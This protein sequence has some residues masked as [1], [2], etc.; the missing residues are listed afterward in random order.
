M[1]NTKHYIAKVH[2]KR[3]IAKVHTKHY[4]AKLFSIIIQQVRLLSKWLVKV[5]GAVCSMHV[6]NPKK[7]LPS[8]LC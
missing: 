5:E 7:Y 2:T 4:I 8:Q 6:I 3:Y 1:L